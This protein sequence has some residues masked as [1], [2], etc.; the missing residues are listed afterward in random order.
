L[1][2]IFVHYNDLCLEIEILH[3]QIELTE[4][5]VKFWYSAG[6]IP[7]GSYGAFKYG[8]NTALNQSEK[9]IKY[10]N[11][12]KERLELLEE[13]KKKIDAAMN[14]FEGLDYKVAKMRYLDGMTLKQIAS[15]L[16]FSYAY[17]REVMSKLR[18]QQ[19][20]Q[21]TYNKYLQNEI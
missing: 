3:E 9:K 15:E 20:Q 1:L 7:L 6:S 4:K 11:R 10:L 19:N 18:K 5:E 16:G 21:T 2:E 13:A 14:Q 12:L 8:A 17:I